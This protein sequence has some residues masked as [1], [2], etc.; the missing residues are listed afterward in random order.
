MSV[1]E[2]KNNLILKVLQTEDKAVLE[3]LTEYFQSLLAEKD[4][5]DELTLAQKAFIERSS[6]QIDEGK[7]IP[8]AEVRAKMHELLNKRKEMADA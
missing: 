8:H 5:W 7:V 1:A 4:W 3:Y 2:V 6:Q